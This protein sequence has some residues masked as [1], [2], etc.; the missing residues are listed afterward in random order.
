MLKKN[1]EIL[2]K[3]NLSHNNITVNDIIRAVNDELRNAAVQII[4]KTINDVQNAILNKFLGTKWNEFDNKIV[5]WICPHCAERSSFVRR[6]TRPRKLKTSEGT[7]N[8]NLHQV[9]CKSC[10]KTFSPFPQLL[11]LKPRV[12]I[13]VEFEEKIV[14]LALENSYDKT[15]NYINEF[16]G[17]TISHTACR[18]IMLRVS[19]SISIEHEETEFDTILIDGTKVKSGFKERGSDIHLAIAPI[20]KIDKSGRKYNEKRIVAFSMG[21][22]HNGFKKQ[23]SKYS[24][25][26][27]IADGESAYSNIMKD[28]FADATHRRCIWHIPRQLF[29]LLY[30]NKVPVKDREV[31]LQALIGIL[32]TKNFYKALSEYFHFIQMFKKLGFHDIVSFLE[33][34]MSGVFHDEKDWNNRKKHTSNSLIEREMREINRRTDIGC[35][36][37]DEGVYKIIKL[38]E[39]KRHST[40]NFDQYFKQNRRPIINLLQ[41]SLC[42]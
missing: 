8:F 30:M 6:G 18:N 27:V 16:T 7:I 17:S 26:N 37:S 4:G 24:C 3:L 41:V 10:S 35:R 20:K 13:S 23:L 28:I 29:H 32:K 42:S 15:S 31:F 33:N 40:H 12:R 9:T 14:K 19:D 39:I 1:Y 2:C 5:P 38:L 34:A 22:S 21:K 11:G 36:W 25:K